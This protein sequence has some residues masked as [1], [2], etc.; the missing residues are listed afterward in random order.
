MENSYTGWQNLLLLSC[1]CARLSGNWSYEHK[2]CLVYLPEMDDNQTR[3]GWSR[4]RYMGPGGSN[5][6][7]AD[8]GCVV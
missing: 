7:V 2:M 5:P 8:M 1:E 6:I 4:K 3:W